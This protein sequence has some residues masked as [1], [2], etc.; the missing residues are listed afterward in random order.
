MFLE[1]P[2]RP[3]QAISRWSVLA[4][5]VAA[6]GAKYASATNVLAEDAPI[7]DHIAPGTK[8]VIGDPATQKALELS[9]A[10]AKLP[11]TVE[12][13]NISGGPQTIEA[14]RARGCSVRC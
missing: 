11:F 10:A 6:A 8:F 14:F 12:W 3:R 1:F 4:S 9:G 13:A 5:I 7:P 2:A